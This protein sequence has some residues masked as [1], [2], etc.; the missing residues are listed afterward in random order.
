M[1]TFTFGAERFGAAFAQSSWLAQNQR[2]FAINSQFH[3]LPP[4]CHVVAVQMRFS[5]NGRTACGWPGSITRLG[6][7]TIDQ[8]A[9]GERHGSTAYPCCDVKRSSRV[10]A[11]VAAIPAPATVTGEL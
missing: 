10:V 4:L 5:L 7:R 1:T 6:K 8:A 3:R 2:P 9:S 11:R